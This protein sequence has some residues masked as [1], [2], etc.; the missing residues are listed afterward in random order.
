[1]S[2]KASAPTSL[3]TSAPA[4]K[5]AHL[6]F[7]IG[8]EPL[9]GSSPMADTGRALEVEGHEVTGCS[10]I[11]GEPQDRW[12]R[13][14]RN[15]DVLIFIRYHGSGVQIRRQLRI[16][17]DEGLLIVR[18]WV[19]SDAWSA[20]NCRVDRK[21]AARLRK[22]VDLNI[23]ASEYV[24]ERLRK[25]S[26]DSFLVPPRAEVV[27][28]REARSAPLPPAV[29][30]YLLNGRQEFYGL[31]YVRHA[32]EER[33]DVPFIVVGDDEHLLGDL[34][35]V[36]SLGFVKDMEPVWQRTGCLMRMTEHD[37]APRMI[38]TALSHGC[39]VIFNKP[40]AGCWLAKSKEDVVEAVDRFTGATGRNSEA[41]V[42]TEE[43]RH[44]HARLL[45]EKVREALADRQPVRNQ[46]LPIMVLNMRRSLYAPI[47]YL[48][49]RLARRSARAHHIPD[50]VE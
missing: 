16:A 49:W 41:P 28:D 45:V 25:V 29:L 7:L 14:C 47:R 4:S 42:Y 40:K 6:R 43:D 11:D 5:P 2:A 3:P 12:R 44:Q 22:L 19:G 17:R 24:R 23:A 33:P 8:G 9:S 37:S 38:E 32:A 48:R 15:H 34:P 30:S 10:D 39:Y 18:L 31:S 26:I 20:A 21:S 36:D 35:N 27:T 50:A 1:M 13:L 46:R